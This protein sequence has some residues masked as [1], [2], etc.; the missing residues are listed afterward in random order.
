MYAGGPT[1]I[2]L[3]SNLLGTSVSDNAAVFNLDA[4]LGLSYWFTQSFKM[5]VSYRFD[6]Y[7]NAMKEYDVNGNIVNDNRF[8]H[9]PMLKATVVFGG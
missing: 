1:P 6:G 7:W 3:P 5:T 9:G 4:Q 2:V 8:Y